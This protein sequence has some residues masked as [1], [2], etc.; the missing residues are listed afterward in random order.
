MVGAVVDPIFDPFQR[1]SRLKSIDIRNRSEFRTLS[2]ADSRGAAAPLLTRCILKQ[3]EILHQNAPFLDKIFENFLGRGNSPFPRPHP[4]PSVLLFQTSGSATERYCSPQYFFRRGRQKFVLKLSCLSY[5]ASCE[6]V[7]ASKVIGE[8]TLNFSQFLTPHCTYLLG[9]PLPD[10]VCAAKLWLFFS[11]CKK[12]GGSAPLRGR[13]MVDLGG[14]NLAFRFALLMNQSLPDFFSLNSGKIAVDEIF[15]LFWI[16]LFV[17]EI[18][19]L[20]V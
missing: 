16:Y 14:Y 8:H 17:P 6:N 10:R 13:Y 20:E 19:E 15:V 2:L 18:F 12:F 11:A 7:F 9:K 5:G 4:N 1:Y 3:R